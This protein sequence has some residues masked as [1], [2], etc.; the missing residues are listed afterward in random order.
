MNGSLR[1]L[2]RFTGILKRSKL[3]LARCLA[4]RRPIASIVGYQTL[5]GTAL[6]GCCAVRISCSAFYVRKMYDYY[7]ENQPM[8]ANLPIIL[9][10]SGDSNHGYVTR[11]V[12]NLLYLS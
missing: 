7:V 11:K 9:K 1:S 4:L 3:G 8:R 12:N 6:G 2:Q 5:Q 10:V